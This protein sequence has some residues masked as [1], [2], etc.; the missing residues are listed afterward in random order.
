MYYIGL[1]QID[2]HYKI[3]LLFIA[4]LLLF[5][6]YICTL[7]LFIKQYLTQLV[8]FYYSSINAIGNSIVNNL[9]EC[10][11]TLKLQDV[12]YFCFSFSY[13]GSK[14]D[15]F[16]IVKKNIHPQKHANGSV[17]KILYY[18]LQNNRTLVAKAHDCVCNL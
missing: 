12:C 17:T 7:Y 15:V 9:L 14:K 2:I 10:C 3:K 6:C 1:E 11:Q 18:L 8:I 5:V 4:Q 13:F 16:G